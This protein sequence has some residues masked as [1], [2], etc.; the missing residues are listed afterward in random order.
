MSCNLR[1]FRAWHKKGT[2]RA[3]STC[4][5]AFPTAHVRRS[6]RP[7][8]VRRPADPEPRLPIQWMQVG[9][10][11]AEW[12]ASL[13]A[14]SAAAVISTV[15]GFSVESPDSTSRP[16]CHLRPVGQTTARHT[17]SSSS[18]TA[19]N[20]RGCALHPFSTWVRNAGAQQGTRELWVSCW[21]NA[22]RRTTPRRPF[23]GTVAAYWGA[24]KIPS[25]M[26][27]TSFPVII[28]LT[29]FG[30]GILAALKQI[31]EACTSECWQLQSR[32]MLQWSTPMLQCSTR[33]EPKWRLYRTT[34]TPLH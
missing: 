12:S 27:R 24:Y 28:V 22:P 4:H 7:P 1:R 21:S 10:R 13:S 14:S 31:N 25:K 8:P 6:D 16:G 30:K 20:A 33:K 2:L 9:H 18:S 15:D 11:K 26:Q 3:V 17:T 5:L 23:G 32:T 19:N 29:L 34:C